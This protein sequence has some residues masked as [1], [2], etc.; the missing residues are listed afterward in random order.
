MATHL[1][2]EGVVKVGSNAIAEVRSFS[3]TQEA[4]T[5]TDTVMGDEWETQKVT[6]KSWSGQLSCYWDSADTTGQG[7]LTI[8]AEVT[9][10][11]YPEGT[12]S[13]D[14]E[15]SGTAIIKSIENQAAHDGLV[16]ASF[17]FQGTGAL[18]IEEVS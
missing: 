1:G 18:T 6:M 3:I 5:A 12:T 14:Q 10:K 7:A 4:A 15:L 8:G 11:L 17:S 16:E 9:L 13:G 2:K